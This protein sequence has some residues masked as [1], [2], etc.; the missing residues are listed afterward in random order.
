M[1][2]ND[3]TERKFYWNV[4]LNTYIPLHCS[5]LCNTA[6]FAT[7]P[8]AVIGRFSTK[9]VLLKYGRKTPVEE[10]NFRKVAAC[11]NFS[12]VSQHYYKMTNS[13]RQAL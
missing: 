6:Y 4:P 13:L 10:Q 11:K 9:K 8:E 2:V 3:S 1:I 7:F 5:Y 12:N